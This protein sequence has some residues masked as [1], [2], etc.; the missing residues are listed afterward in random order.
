MG[1]NTVP[2]IK[3]IETVYKGYRF[4]SRL[5][6]RWAVFFDAL[7]V[8]WQYEVEG[9][10]L[11]SG[12]YLPD[13]FLPGRGGFFEIKPEIDFNLG[14]R[15]GKHPDYDYQNINTTELRCRELAMASGNWVH[16]AYGDPLFVEEHDLHTF[17]P[18]AGNGVF[19]N[20]CYSQSFLQT[21]LFNGCLN[22]A[23]YKIRLAALKSRQA[24]FEHGE[25]P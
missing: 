25:T 3:P 17:Y 24:R 23:Y 7:D 9:Y 6:A 21:A 19:H 18:K 1:E 12:W 20:R 8:K 4:R 22:N 10:Q 13:F 5:E 2:D 16:I 14:E 11:K 15:Y